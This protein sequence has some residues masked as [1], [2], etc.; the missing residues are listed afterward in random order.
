MADYDYELPPERVANHP[1]ADR[2][3]SRLLVARRGTNAVTH[4]RF[5]DVLE[6]LPAPA[7]LVVNN[8]RVIRARV[9]LRK[10]SGGAVE[11]LLLEP[12]TPSADPVVA[13]AARGES[14]WNVM[15]SGRKLESGDV[16][17]GEGSLRVRVDERAGPQARVT[18]QWD[19]AQ[20]TLGELLLGLGHTPLPPYI[21]RDDEPEDVTRYQTVYA[22][23][24][25]SV[26]APTA[27]LHF[28]PELLDALE[29]RGISRAQVTL[30]VGAGT[31]RP[32][33]ATDAAEHEMHAERATVDRAT[34]QRDRKSV[35]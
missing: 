21:K 33:F 8:T 7:L 13:L 18:L 11:M 23:V 28:T 12:V 34:V 5:V 26:A 29:T 22:R 35:V 31:F 3:G 30:H 14:Q 10:A 4:L 25:G 32:V 16:L 2:Q 1:V 27:G 19:A 9:P 15:L 17:R 24:E 6:H 20:G